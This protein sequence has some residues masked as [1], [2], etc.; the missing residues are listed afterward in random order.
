MQV[1]IDDERRDFHRAAAL[2]DFGFSF[3][4]DVAMRI[5]VEPHREV[6]VELDEFL[7]LRFNLEHEAFAKSRAPTPAGSRCCTR[8][9]ARR[10]RS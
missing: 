2:F 6:A 9:M 8:S 4:F 5:F 1:A 3:G 10:A 7:L